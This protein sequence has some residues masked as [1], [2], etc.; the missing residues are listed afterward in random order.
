MPISSKS[1]LEKSRIIANLCPHQQQFSCP[2]QLSGH[3]QCCQ[4]DD[5]SARQKKTVGGEGIRY[6]E[7]VKK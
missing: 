5:V 1:F 6:C 3:K 4:P 7:I 2:T